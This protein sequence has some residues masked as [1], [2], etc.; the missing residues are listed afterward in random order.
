MDDGRRHGGV[1]CLLRAKKENPSRRPVKTVRAEE[2][3]S[4]PD[5]KRLY[6][7]LGIIANPDVGNVGKPSMP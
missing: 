2:E 6:N 7:G 5:L 3:V 1:V 4:L